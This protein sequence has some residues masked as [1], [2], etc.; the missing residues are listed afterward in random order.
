M[1]KN[2][3]PGRAYSTASFAF[4]AQ[5]SFD[6]FQANL[7]E[8]GLLDF[9]SIEWTRRVLHEDDASLDGVVTTARG[10]KV[11]VAVSLI[12]ESGEW[13]LYSLHTPG[14]G[15]AAPS[16]NR[17]SLVG[18]GAGFNDM[19]NKNVPPQKEIVG[20]VRDTFRQFGEALAQKDFPDFYN[21]I[22][23]AWQSQIS[24]RNFERTFQPFLDSKI[25][26]RGLAQLDPVFDGRP[27][28]TPEGV[29]AVNGSFPSKP[30]VV[31]ALKYVYEMPSWKLFGISVNVLK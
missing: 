11:P 9:T 25:D 4:Q 1:L 30:R 20:L 24:E 19:F 26:L 29:L 18:K 5:Q 16:E 15:N 2:Q 6:S 17:F 21:S 22:A 23:L 12:R 13:K 14:R 10:Q 31:F 3:Q 7:S 28:I 8:L 27:Q